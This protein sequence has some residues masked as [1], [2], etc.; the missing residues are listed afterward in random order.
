MDSG[1][2]SQRS[3]SLLAA[4]GGANGTAVMRS[5]GGM[6]YV[7]KAQCPARDLGCYFERL[8]S[9]P[10]AAAPR[11]AK[12]R[13]S[14][15]LLPGLL[16]QQLA[17][18]RPRDGWWV[19]KELTRY[20]LRPNGRTSD[21]L[22]AVR[23][24]VGLP[25][26]GTWIALH[27]R[28]GDKRDQGAAER[29][30]PF[31]D[32]MYARAARAVAAAVGADSVLLASSEPATLERLPRLLAPLRTYSMPARYFIAVPEGKE[33][34]HV[35]ERAAQAEQ[36]EGRSLVVQLLLLAQAAAFVGTGTSNLGQLVAKA[37]AFAQPTPAALDLS[38]AGLA[39]MRPADAFRNGSSSARGVW[40]IPWAAKDEARCR[41]YV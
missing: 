23:D 34:A 32:D 24:E 10:P 19:R 18:R 36:D 12:G 6:R 38:C 20:L 27:V 16:T 31:S 9:C 39:A 29:G 33:A 37:M 11:R 22:H 1:A 26:T 25:A 28:R 41:R 2:R 7:N 5:A 30:E 17:L 21:A 13:K 35:V 15:P 40:R 4:D 8:S 14:P 3:T